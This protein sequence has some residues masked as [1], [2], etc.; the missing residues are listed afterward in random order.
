MIC[1]WVNFIWFVILRRLGF[2]CGGV[3]RV[4]ILGVVGFRFCVRGICCFRF[5]GFLGFFLVS[6][7]IF[8]FWNIV[9]Y[10]CKFSVN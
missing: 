2:G 9:F 7:F 4:R 3:V 10:L 6:Y 1:E 8:F 5:E